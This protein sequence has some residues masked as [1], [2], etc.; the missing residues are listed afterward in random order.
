MVVCHV[1]QENGGYKQRY[2]SILTGT[3]KSQ[4]SGH[5]D[6]VEWNGGLVDWNGRMDW[7]GME[8]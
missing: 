8:W 1:A 4:F 3:T 5:L 7:N 6:S 2:C